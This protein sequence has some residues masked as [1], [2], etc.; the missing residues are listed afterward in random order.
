[1]SNVKGITKADMTKLVDAYINYKKA[2]AEFKRIKTKVVDNLEPGIYENEVGKVNKYIV[3]RKLLNSEK[4]AE[5]HPEV[6]EL[7]EEYKELNTQLS[8]S[9]TKY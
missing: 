5:E 1:M 2:E 7:M 6:I 3:K 4:L 8:V 9:I